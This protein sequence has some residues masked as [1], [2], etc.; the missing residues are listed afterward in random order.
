MSHASAIMAHHPHGFWKLNEDSGTVAHD[1]SGYGLDMTT[2]ESAPSSGLVSL[3]PLWGAPPGPPGEQAANFNVG[4][5][6]FD[7]DAA[8]VSR[9]WAEGSS[10][11]AGLWLSRNVDVYSPAMGHGTPQREVR[12]GWEIGVNGGIPY[13]LFKG[14]PETPGWHGQYRNATAAPLPLN[15]W[16]LVSLSYDSA[17]GLFKLYA[18]GVLAAT[19]AVFTFAPAGTV[20]LWIG[21]DGGVGSYSILKSSITA[22]YAFLIEDVLTDEEHSAISAG[23]SPA[24]GVYAITDGL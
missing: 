13:A 23:I 8:R 15:T 12:P 18:D 5:T 1:S 20:S 3:P 16:I 17:A 24:A 2:T 4:S 11:T 14:T 22:S 10:F 9:S 6:G 19:S 21:H 7:G